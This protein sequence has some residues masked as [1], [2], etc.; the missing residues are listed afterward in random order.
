MA[1]ACLSCRMVVSA[2]CDKWV[3][4]SAKPCRIV[5]TKL[6]PKKCQELKIFMR[7]ISVCFQMVCHK[8]QR[9]EVSTYGSAMP[10]SG[11]WIAGIMIYA[12]VYSNSL[13]VSLNMRRRGKTT[14]SISTSELSGHAQY[15]A[16][17][18]TRTFNID[19]RTE[20][21][22]VVSTFAFVSLFLLMERLHRTTPPL[23]LRW[24]A[25]TKS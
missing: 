24:A 5:L 3:L 12:K 23:S 19:Q 10:S 13:M 2:S 11:I 16:I 6:C 1:P 8:T 20:S 18:I 25:R 21:T 7:Q 9:Q 4:A 15:Q 14:T 17:Q 22:H